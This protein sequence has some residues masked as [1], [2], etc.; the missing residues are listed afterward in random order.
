MNRILVDE[1][2]DF[3]SKKD[4]TLYIDIEESINL[5]IANSSYDYEINV[6]DSFVNILTIFQNSNDANIKININ[7]SKVIYNLISYNG[8]N[9]NIKVNL[10]TSNSSFDLFNSIISVS[11]Q[12]INVNI[13]HNASLTDSNVYNCASTIKEGSVKFNITSKVFKDSIKCKVNQ[14]SRI[15]SL[16]SSN[17]NE[18]NPNLLIGCYDTLASHSAFIG[19]FK[20]E[21]VFYMQT[22][23]I[24]KKDAYNLLLEGFLIG[25]L[26]ISSSEKDYLK[27]K[28]NR[29]WR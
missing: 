1:G 19:K 6:K 20:D 21:D 11:N 9:E 18:I 23:G 4:D 26:D 2:L 17:D 28:L 29:N 15:I 27:E 14:E 12:E 8:K 16:N 5:L 13:L 3:V 7:N 25:K 24:K 10:N 22:R